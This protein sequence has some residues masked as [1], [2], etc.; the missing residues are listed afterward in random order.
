MER[1]AAEPLNQVQKDDF[2]K[3][4]HKVLEWLPQRCKVGICRVAVSGSLFSG[5]AS[6]GSVCGRGSILG[7]SDYVNTLTSLSSITPSD[8]SAT[9]TQLPPVVKPST[10]SFRRRVLDPHRAA[11][12]HPPLPLASTI[13]NTSWRAMYPNLKQTKASA[14]GLVRASPH[15]SCEPTNFVHVSLKNSHGNVFDS[16]WNGRFK[17]S[18]LIT[19][20]WSQ[21][22]FGFPQLDSDRAKTMSNG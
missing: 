4:K 20:G 14:T 9:N 22:C 8:L 18:V 7:K 1:S 17:E 15:R 19:K 6:S 12:H 2:T 13:P 11:G 3:R 16:R 21:G 5:S 10:R